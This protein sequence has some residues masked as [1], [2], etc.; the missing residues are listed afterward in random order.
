M[1]RFSALACFL[2]LALF[3]LQTRA[4]TFKADPVHSS[5]IFRA[6]HANAGHVWGRF[7]D[8]T[9]TFALDDTD[10]SKSSFSVE[11]PVANVDTHNAQRDGHLKSPDFFNAKQYPTITFKSTSAKAEGNML[12]VTG[13]LEMH[14]VKK[15]ITVPVEILGKGELPPGVK[16][17]GIE[18]TFSVKMTD[19]GI[20]G[21]P[22]AVGDEIKVIVALEGVKQ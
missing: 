11:I 6:Q 1:K 16:R 19:F 14:G 18:A 15:T 4:D 3:A 7:N 10:L 8:P 21:L 22:G 2:S 17:A 13:E 12:Q 5:V 9:G 20:K